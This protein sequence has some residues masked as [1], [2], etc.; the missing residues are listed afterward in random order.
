MQKVEWNS[1]FSVNNDTLDYEHQELLT[2]YSDMVD[3]VDNGGNNLIMINLLSN[4]ED[5]A[6]THFKTEEAYMASISYPR[7]AEHKDLHR[8]YSKRV[9]DFTLVYLN[10]NSNNPSEVLKFLR[11]WWT[12]HI[13]EE[14]SKYALHV[15]EMK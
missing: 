14:D 7:L 8:K 6:L 13:L 12:H 2:I 15:K 1:K 9:L 11:N 4:L 5:Y 3:V 10:Q